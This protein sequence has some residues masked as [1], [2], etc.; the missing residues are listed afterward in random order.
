MRC[1][2]VHWFSLNA[3]NR[4]QQ[5]LFLSGF[6]REAK[7]FPDLLLKRVTAARSAG[8]FQHL[9]QLELQLPKPGFD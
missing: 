2:V 1:D 7:R 8:D 9:K 5:S 4:G 6:T 3:D